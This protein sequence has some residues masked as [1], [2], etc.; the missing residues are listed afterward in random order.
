M[1]T[2][3][4]PEQLEL[5]VKNWICWNKSQQYAIELERI[6]MAKDVNKIRDMFD[7]RLSFGT[8]GLRSAMAPG[9]K[10]I[11]ELVVIQSAQGLLYYMISVFGEA[12]KSAGIFLGYDGRYNSKRF[13]ELS[14]SVFLRHSVKVYLIRTVCPTPFV[15]FGVKEY[16]CCG[17]VMV[18][19]SHNPKEDNGY[20][21][22]WNNGTQVITPHDKNIQNYILEH[23]EPEEGVW[24]VEKIYSNPL[25]VDPLDDLQKKYYSCVNEMLIPGLDKKSTNIIF[26]YTPM[27]GVGYSYI[28]NAFE[29]ANFNPVVAVEQQK[30]PDPDFP[31]VPFPNP[32]EG[33]S[34]LK[35]AIETAENNGSRIILANDPDADRL[36]V[37][38][39]PIG[40]EG[41]KVFTGNELGALLGWWMIDSYKKIH[42]QAH[43]K[44]VML[45]STVSSAVL[46]SIAKV[47]G[48][49]FEET[50]TGFKWMGNRAHQLAAEGY[51]VLYAFEESI[52]YMCGT[53]V[54][55][56]DGI[57]A[58]I[59]IAEMAI[60]LEKENSTLSSALETIYNRYGWHLSVNSYFICNDSLTIKNIFESLRHDYNY[61]KSI[62][63]GRYS[64]KS[65]RDLTVGYDSETDDHKPLLPVSKST[66]MITFNFDNGLKATLR[67]SGTEPKIKYYAELCT[68]PKDC[69]DIDKLKTILKEMVEAIIEEFLK[70]QKNSL[71][72][73]ST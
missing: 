22:Y 42:G 52:G 71:I 35:L 31:T 37:A 66:Q 34:A 20:K 1:D 54:L 6:L 36:A 51:E 59:K 13:A 8:A 24:D 26:T 61:P 57:S 45:S 48:V 10:R 33:K 60:Y 40:S 19:A 63:N 3:F 32:E 17:G 5:L 18:T 28:R 25:L 23:L 15:A 30:H 44:L 2:S 16:K 62:M 7:G 4:L 68:D 39:H 49:L 43:P 27:H 55:D 12:L 69:V 67:T 73:R 9:F 56:K 38:E 14:A 65:V 11:N 47:E 58:A 41:W 70:P 29:K 21:V 64:I 53:A 72:Y 46:K 50:L